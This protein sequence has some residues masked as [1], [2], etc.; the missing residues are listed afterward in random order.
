MRL[1]RRLAGLAMAL[2]L[3]LAVGA[4]SLRDIQIA[5]AWALEKGNAPALADILARGESLGGSFAADDP[6]TL[7]S[8]LEALSNLPS[9]AELASALTSRA[10]RGQLGGA[11]RRDFVLAPG[12]TREVAFLLADDERSFIEARLKRGSEGADIDLMLLGEAGTALAKD[13]GP[14]TG[15]PGVGALI[16]H[17][18]EVCAR[19]TVSVS[20]AG[21]APAEIA[22]LVPLSARQTC[23]G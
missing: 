6:F 12:A 4:E 22:L 7:A 17:L 11:P 21:A 14:E 15:I 2:A 18:P 10:A 1:K 19:V 3:P 13:V 20:N 23:E 5:A 8:Y 9:G 16:M